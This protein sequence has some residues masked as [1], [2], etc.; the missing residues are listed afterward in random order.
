LR[1]PAGYVADNV[2]LAY[3]GTV[4]S[5]QG[6][7]VTTARGLVTEATTAQALYVMMSRG[8]QSNHAYIV[9]GDPDREPHQQLPAPH[10][11]AVLAGILHRDDEPSASVTDTARDL[12][13]QAAS[14]ARL[15]VIFAD[16]S[17][18][19]RGPAYQQL[20]AD[21][22]GPDTAHRAVA[23]PAWASLVRALGAA[24]TAGWDSRQLLIQALT[25]RELGTAA[26]TAAVL[27]WRCTAI[28]GTDDIT[29]TDP[30]GTPTAGPA[31]TWAERAAGIIHAARGDTL[32][33]PVSADAADALTHTATA[34]DARAD[35]LAHRLAEAA[36]AGQAGGYDHGT[37]PTWL[38]ALGP[39]P[40]SGRDR[41]ARR[42]V[43]LDQ[44]RAVATYQD[45]TGYQPPDQAGDPAAD[46]IGPCPPLGD[47]EARQL[48]AA[49]RRALADAP[50]A[51]T[52]RALR[53]DRLHAWVTDGLTA[54]TVQ[55]PDYVGH[56]L[57]T[58]SLRAR[59]Q[60]S[61]VH[62]LRHEQATA[63]RQ[64]AAADRRRW[65]RDPATV[66]RLTHAHQQA[67]DR[68]TRA[69]TTL[70]GI[71]TQL[72]TVTGLH[73]T[74]QDWDTATRDTRTR[75][76]LAAQELA[77]RSHHYPT[78][79]VA[80]LRAAVSC[81]AG[82]NPLAPGMDTRQAAL[83]DTQLAQQYAI[84]AVAADWFHSHLHD[85]WAGRY[86]ASRGLTQPAAAA[87]AGYAP[88]RP[89]HWTL[90]LD[91]LRRLGYP[92]T[93]IR[94][95]GLA[96]PSRQGQLIDRFRDRV[97]IPVLDHADRPIGFLARKPDID[98]DPDN[99]KYLNP[100]RTPLYD[101]SQV[102][103]GLDAD[104]VRELRAG[105]RPIIVE[106]PMDRLAV[107]A[108]A[109]D[110]VPLATCGTA[111][112]DAHLDQLAQ[113]TR[114][115]RIILGFDAD[116]AGRNA[117]L[118]AGQKL[119]H[120]GIPPPDIDLYT[121]PDGRDPADLLTAHGPD[122]L[123]ATLN[124]P[125][126][127]ASLL[128]LLID[129]HLD[130]YDTPTSSRPLRELPVAAHV[131]YETT[132]ILADGWRTRLPQPGDLPQLQ[133]QLTRIAARTGTAHRDLNNYLLD[134][135]IPTDERPAGPEQDTDPDT[136]ARTAEHRHAS[137][138]RLE[139]A[140]HPEPDA[141]ANAVG[142]DVGIDANP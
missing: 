55:Q 85:R 108:A 69:E 117:A 29:G 19:V 84:Q 141:D 132:R 52:I 105:A 4:H 49:A 24:Q 142:I 20:I 60:H 33:Q 103:Y 97:I 78:P 114:L 94:T 7:T 48:W 101:K 3:A 92:D 67:A 77:L 28:T 8:Q 135:L 75:A 59:A 100:T 133:Q 39:V 56:E 98:T 70:T 109:P 5:A 130:H 10:H 54:E 95:A 81:P 123:A 9:T 137:D 113:H 25:Q 46:P 131:A 41:A 15:R 138:P 134:L 140:T 91:H 83:S 125:H 116:P 126:R 6:R 119:T 63:A 14:I 115:D 65:R 128:D 80:A 47:P 1:L 34:L 53:S 11:L 50:A 58:L 18:A 35:T 73:H 37:T 127:R 79:P 96:A 30:A 32:H 23:D 124:D 45:A 76:R 27:H 13:D 74:W 93:A 64:L 40:T 82:P 86:L 62:R 106:G 121:P 26:D 110:L 31:P 22:A 57:R 72:R 122:Q 16:L 118:A 90:L 104:A 102:L 99:P 107:R 136:S 120:R 12:A 44:A 51:A 43:W 71:Q 61:R 139:H 111:L 2:Q 112:T 87:R 36:E 129:R 42:A 88:S 66:V 68:L 89:G 17:T 21:H 38:R